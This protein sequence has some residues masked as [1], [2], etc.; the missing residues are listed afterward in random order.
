MYR[1]AVVQNGS[2]NRSTKSVLPIAHTQITP[3]AISPLFF[4]MM[5]FD[6]LIPLQTESEMTC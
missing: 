5:P 3:T 2:Y 1:T 6:Q 4:Y